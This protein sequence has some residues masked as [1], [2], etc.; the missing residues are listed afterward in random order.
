MDEL[1]T[2]FIFKELPK[3][4]WKLGEQKAEARFG[5]TALNPSGDWSKF[6]P[7]YEK[8]SKNGVEPC[9]CTV[10]NSH[11]AWITAANYQGF[12]FPQNVS[13]RFSGVMAKV[14]PPGANPYDTCES[15]R[16]WGMVNEEV[17]PF[18][19]DIKSVVDFYHPDPM[20]EGLIA[21]A[22]KL[23]QQYELGHKNIWND[24]FG[25]TM[26]K[27]TILKNQMTKGPVC[28]SVVGWKFNGTVYYK[29]AGDEDSHWTLLTG[30]YREGEWWEV[31]DSY[32]P[33]LKKVAWDTDFQ[34]AELY[35][36]Q[37]NTNGIAPNDRDYLDLL[38]KKAVE[39]L[40]RLL[41]KYVH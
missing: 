13:E 22:R 33:F 29:D 23:V 24:R 8:Q 2:G 17:L 41:L 15:I 3:S 34:M 10:I 26:N 5:A 27:P 6:I 38:L 9:D 21:E 32:S 20:D 28:V 39:T 12:Q 4:A 1:R 30:R 16:R 35:L 25:R 7:T 14:R 31:N 18:N 11:R 40:K 19:D 37:K 36:I